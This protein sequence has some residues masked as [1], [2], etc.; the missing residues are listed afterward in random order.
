[1]TRWP[2]RKSGGFTLVE[3]QIALLIVALIAAL[4]SG[5]LRLSSKTWVKVSERQ[6]TAEH[7][8]LLAGYLRRHISSAQFPEVATGEH[9]AVTGFFGDQEQIS[10]L[11]S[12]PTF[13]EGGDLYW[14]NIKL[15]GGDSS[16]HFDLVATYFP[17]KHDE[18]LRFDNA[19]VPY[20]D[21]VEQTRMV[22][23]EN[24]ADLTFAY[25]DRDEEGAHQWLDEWQPDT[26]SPMLISLNIA[27]S[28]A[29]GQDYAPLPEIL[30]TP[31]FAGQRL[32]R[33]AFDGGF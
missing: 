17:F 20:V 27:T 7:R 24:V 10:F 28:V 13:H 29:G 18:A 19:G 21:D 33:E 1:M 26:A 11:A 16:D 14:W 25:L 30:I 31:R 9:G 5:A 4:M 23:A 12:F 6:D 15:E 32:S 8:Y 22:I 3:L 2:R